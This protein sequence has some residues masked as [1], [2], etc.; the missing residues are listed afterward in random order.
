MSERRLTMEESLALSVESSLGPHWQ[1]R[2][3]GVADI[4]ANTLNHVSGLLD[5]LV[6]RGLP[7][8]PDRIL[9]DLDAL[10]GSVHYRMSKRG[11]E[12][13]LQNTVR[14]AEN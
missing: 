9:N 12:A 3:V 13:R 4:V 1:I 6:E 14:A 5:A 10:G 11:V 7:I 2:G 8:D